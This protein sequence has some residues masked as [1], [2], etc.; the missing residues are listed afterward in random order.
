M[1][2]FCILAAHILVTLESVVAPRID[3]IATWAC[4]GPSLETISIELTPKPPSTAYDMLQS[5]CKPLFSLRRAKSRRFTQNIENTA[6]STPATI[7]PSPAP[8]VLAALPMYAKSQHFGFSLFILLASSKRK[9]L[10][11]IEAVLHW[12]PLSLWHEY[13]IHGSKVV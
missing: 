2:L 8:V 5:A 12:P 11:L 10:M 7:A 13:P 9:L 4:T 1:V 3:M 6:T